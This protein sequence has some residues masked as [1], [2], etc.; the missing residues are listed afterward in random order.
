MGGSVLQWCKPLGLFSPSQALFHE[1]APN[2]AP[3]NVREDSR[4]FY[5][6]PWARAQIRGY[7]PPSISVICIADA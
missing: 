2:S 5:K 4:G 1:L 7:R 6:V 3:S